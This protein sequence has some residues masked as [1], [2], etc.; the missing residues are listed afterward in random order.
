MLGQVLEVARELTGARYAALGVLDDEKRELH[1]FL[2]AGVDEQTR[3]EIGPLPRGRG[4]LGELIRNPQ[5]LR[6]ER[7][8]RDP[9]SYG[10][11]PGHPPM[12][13]FLGVPIE[14]RGEVYGNLYLTEKRDGALF[15]EIDEELVVLL[16]Q[17]AAVAIENARQIGAE[18]LRLSLEAAEGERR[19]WARE[20]HDE[21]L[22]ELGALKV[23]LDANRDGGSD[24]ASAAVFGQAI[25]HVE[26]GIQSLEEIIADLR[27]A[28]LDELGLA[29]AVEALAERAA[30]TAGMQ[31]TSHV[32][33]GERSGELPARLAPELEVAIYR[34]VQEGVRNAVKHAD[35]TL[36]RIRIVRHGELIEAAVNDDG[37][38]FDPATVGSGLGL[39]GIKERV[40]LAGGAVEIESDSSAGTTVKAR[41]P[42]R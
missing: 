36:V 40:S 37:R 21:A 42:V 1:R 20:L 6:L 9:R 12:T 14:I 16:S 27:P 4:I 31:V 34:L 33:L 5:P 19:R 2:F 11:P 7:I 41:F 8:D 35:G 24:D 28:S 3:N 23:L 22:Q 32:D 17:W 13:T 25:G 10:F 18:R 26:H 29:A 38:G 39:L 30:A 15:D